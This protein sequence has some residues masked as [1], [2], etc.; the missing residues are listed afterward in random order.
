M[1]ALPGSRLVLCQNARP[2]PCSLLA[3]RC[4]TPLQ[5]RPPP[6]AAPAC[7]PPLPAPSLP[8]AAPLFPPPTSAS[9]ALGQHMVYCQLAPAS[10]HHVCMSL[11]HG[12]RDRDQCCWHGVTPHPV[13]TQQMLAD[14]VWPGCQGGRSQ[15][16]H[17]P[18]ARLQDLASA[19]VAAACRS[20][21]CHAPDQQRGTG[22]LVL[23]WSDCVPGN[24]GMTFPI[25]RFKPGFSPWSSG[26]PWGFSVLSSPGIT[27]YLWSLFINDYYLDLKKN[28]PMK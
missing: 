23:S 4:R 8:P 28:N 21:F 25:L 11:G 1:P 16:S 13:H 24:H 17:C 7:P 22:R 6:R 12:R 10:G 5:H 2:A 3:Q 27:C 14:W 18:A 20:G 26:I 15:P 9:P 19:E